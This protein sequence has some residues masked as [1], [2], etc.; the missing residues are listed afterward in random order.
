MP[1]SHI[2]ASHRA[3]LETARMIAD[4]AATTHDGR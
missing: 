4:P 2:L 3:T 1:V